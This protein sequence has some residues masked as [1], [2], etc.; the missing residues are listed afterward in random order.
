MIYT[1]CPGCVFMPTNIHS[2]LDFY[3][4]KNQ[5][6]NQP[7]APFTIIWVNGIISDF[8]NEAKI[9]K[10]PDISNFLRQTAQI[11]VIAENQ[12]G[13]ILEVTP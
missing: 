1:N 2:V 5:I 10:M 11:R 7:H 9:S 13:T 8:E 4:V 6:A 12:D 3:Y